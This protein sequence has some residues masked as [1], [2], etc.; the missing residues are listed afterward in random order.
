MKSAGDALGEALK[1]GVVFAFATASTLLSYL[2][3]SG[4]LAKLLH[5][6]TIPCLGLGLL[7]GPLYVL[8]V[9]LAYRVCGSWHGVLT[10]LLVSSFILFKSTWYGVS[11][12]SWFG[13]YGLLSFIALGVLTEK[14]NG[15][16]ASIACLVINWIAL[17]IHVGVWPKPIYTALLVLL[18][19]FLSGLVFDKAASIIA[20]KAS[21]KL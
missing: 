11:S 15:G 8:W 4:S 5:L 21:F 19:T 1:L 10:A 3:P 18:A 16:V 20:G 14:V 9:S 12:P 17:G 13:V 2:T 7:A 6:D